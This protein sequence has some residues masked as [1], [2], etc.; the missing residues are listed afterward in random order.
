MLS[1]PQITIL[2]SLIAGNDSLKTISQ[3]TDRSRSWVSTVLSTLTK[4]GFCTKERTGNVV[5]YYP[6]AAAPIQKLIKAINATPGF[7]FETFLSGLN[8]RILL[9]CAFAPKTSKL[10][11]RNL[12]TSVKAIQNRIT[13]L[14][15]RGLLTREKNHQLISFNKKMYPWIGW[16][17]Q[18]L[19]LYSDKPVT[20]LWKFEER[21]LFETRKKEEIAGVLTGFSRYSE[22]NVPLYLNVFCCYWPKKRLGKE[23]IFIHSLWEIDHAREI[24][25]ALTFYL[26]H[27]LNEKKLE[28]LAREYDCG[29]RLEDLRRILRQEKTSILS[30]I[31][32]EELKEFF[33]DYGLQ[34]NKK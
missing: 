17:L 23:E 14:Q 20:I 31:K 24:M 16:F 12:G 5:R 9:F 4:R 32:E 29:E 2:I 7:D 1:K 15:S 3:Q 6:G 10:I 30:F 26:K 8:L 18:E 19:R 13:V 11:A 28:E 27:R 25:L 33:N 22:L 34:W 21:M